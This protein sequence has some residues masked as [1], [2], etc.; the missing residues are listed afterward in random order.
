MTSP[1]KMLDPKTVADRLAAGQAV[2]IDIRE[3]DEFARSH[4]RGALSYPLSG[5]EAV[6]LTLRPDADVIF[7]CR[8][9]M[10]TTGA[11][12]RLAARVTGPAYLLEG[13]LDNWVKAGLPVETDVRAPMEIMRQ[14][15]IAAGSLVFLGTLLGIFVAPAFL[16]I[17][18]FVGLGLSFAG[19]TGFCGMARLLALAPWNRRPHTA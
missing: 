19:A 17:P 7:T 12:D 18:A 2:L 9:G 13:G 10:R 15:Q 14:V 1:V 3:P 8:S 4:I 11:C 5:W 6:H 16:A